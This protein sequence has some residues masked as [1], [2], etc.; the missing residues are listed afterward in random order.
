ME[1]PHHPTPPL[2]LDFYFV[3]S[4]GEGRLSSILC[5]SLTHASEIAYIQFTFWS[6]QFFLISDAYYPLSFLNNLDDLNKMF[7][8]KV[9][10]TFKNDHSV[11]G[12]YICD[13]KIRASAVEKH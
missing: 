12:R 13:Y 4:G 1:L 7:K 3:F 11:I 2:G 6:W 8:H 10:F 5:V 9:W